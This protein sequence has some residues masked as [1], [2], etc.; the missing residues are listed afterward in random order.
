MFGILRGFQEDL[1]RATWS[2]VIIP[3]TAF[4]RINEIED[5]DSDPNF[6]RVKLVIA[7]PI[8]K[9]EQI[10]NRW[11]KDHIKGRFFNDQVTDYSM[12]ICYRFQR[13]KE[14]VL[15]KLTWGG[16]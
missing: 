6:I 11:C 8:D 5:Y 14:A 16:I 10:L 9:A 12:G 7:N 2:R 13:P 1:A 3:H 15:F 4:A